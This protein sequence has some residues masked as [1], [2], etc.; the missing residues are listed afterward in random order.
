MNP[1]TRAKLKKLTSTCSYLSKD[2]F[3]RRVFNLF[4]NSDMCLPIG[5]VSCALILAKLL[6]LIASK[7]KSNEKFTVRCLVSKIE[8]CCSEMTQKIQ[9]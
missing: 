7:I 3:K 8:G 6:G 9:K 1:L 2:R 5:Q 4:A